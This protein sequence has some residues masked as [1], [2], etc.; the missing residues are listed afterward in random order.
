MRNPIFVLIR[1]VVFILFLSLVPILRSNAQTIADTTI[2]TKVDKEPE[3][4][5]GVVKTG[6]FLGGTIHY[7]AHARENNIQ[8]TVELSFI[9]ETD[10]RLTNIKVMK[11]VATDLDAEAI[12]VLHLSPKWSPGIK[13]GQPVR[14]FYQMPISFSLASD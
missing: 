12:R 10:G 5:G 6:R 3:F 14:T 1:T 9:V 7:P 11:S 2:Y 4:V 8:G 13:D